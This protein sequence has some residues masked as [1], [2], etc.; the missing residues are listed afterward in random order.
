MSFRGRLTVFFVAIVVVPMI[1]VAVLVVRVTDDSRDGKADARLAAGLETGQVVYNDALK[2]SS[3]A[4][5]EIAADPGIGPALRKPNPSFLERAAREVAVAP[6][7]ATAAFYADGERVARAGAE[8]G[9]ARTRRSVELD[10]EQVGEIEVGGLTPAGFAQKVAALSGTEA[11]VVADRG[12]LAGTIDTGQA[13]LPSGPGGE[14]AELPGGDFRVAALLLDG[15]P[16]GSRLVLATRAAEGFVA[17]EP[18]VAGVLLAF[19]AL[20]SLLILMLLRMLQRQVATMLAAARRI[21]SGDFSGEVPA[22]GN[23]EMAGLAREFNKMSDQLSEQM[24]QLRR[25][26]EQLDQSVRRIG[27]AFASGLDRTALLEIVIETA[28]AAC[29]AESGRMMLAGHEGTEAE[30]GATVGAD[31]GAALAEAVTVA[32][33]RN[34]PTQAEHGEARA[35]AQPLT[36]SGSP[37]KVLGAMV[38]GRR[39]SPFS[40]ADREVLRYLIGQTAVSV[41]NIGLHERVAE[42]AVTDELT[43]LSNNRHFRQ[44][45]ERESARLGRFGGEI[46]LVMLDVDDFKKVNDTY[47]HLQGDQVLEAIGRVLRLESRGV[48]EPARYGGEEFVLALPETPKPGAVE[49]AERI[50]ERIERTEV[51]GVDGNSP[52]TVT[53]SIG[54]A[55]MPGDGREIQ[56][57]IAA[58]DRAL[59]DAKRR[60]KNRV[61]AADGR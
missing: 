38:V 46:S 35:I 47:G 9:I 1:A 6:G 4:I 24:Q 39:G 33:E 27:E 41:E 7:V 23:D 55:T 54:V 49:V 57:V 28:L 8:L 44:W 36:V 59:Y 3:A 34:E 51:A 40:A 19:F 42:Q 18:L 61:V 60:G 53:A 52:L 26:R 13:A 32:L 12:V 48:D 45:M 14:T 58:A 43:G 56:S 37:D 15:A 22:E 31:L 16:P 50:R 21:G 25:Q 29:E 11:A 10:G 20:A 17:S 30:A 5:D 2:S